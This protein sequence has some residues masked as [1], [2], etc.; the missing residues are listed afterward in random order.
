MDGL[1]RGCVNYKQYHHIEEQDGG[2]TWPNLE[3]APS[4]DIHNKDR[5]LHFTQQIKVT[6]EPHNGISTPQ[7]QPGSDTSIIYQTVETQQNIPLQT[8]EHGSKELKKLAEILHLCKIEDKIL[9]TRKIYGDR[10]NWV[11]ICPKQIKPLIIEKTH[12]QHHSGTRK[13]L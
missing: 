8:I 3:K 5:T 2:P 11:T 9:K 12:T 7:K 6:N 10:E 13:N 1:S 4:N